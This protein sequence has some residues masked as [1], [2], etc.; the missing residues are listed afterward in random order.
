MQNKIPG[1]K[2]VA[3]MA[4]TTKKRIANSQSQN[5]QKLKSQSFFQLATTTTFRNNNYKP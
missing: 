1:I 4:R 2:T 3:I 5:N